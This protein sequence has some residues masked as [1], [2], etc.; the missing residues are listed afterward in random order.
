MFDLQCLAFQADIT[1]V[2][3]FMLG[4]ETSSRSF[5]EIGLSAT[6]SRQSHHGEQ[7]G[8]HPEVREGQRVL[9]AAV[10]VFSGEASA[11]PDG[12]GTLLDRTLLL[13]G[14]GLSNGNE[15]SHL[16][17]PLLWSAA[18]ISSTAGAIWSAGCIRR[19]RICS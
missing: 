18:A 11:M 5:P 6:A 12:D 4:R 2:F 13:Y 9:H 14:A 16:D 8:G 1:R 19:W 15:H 10:R 7:A 17:L 3:T